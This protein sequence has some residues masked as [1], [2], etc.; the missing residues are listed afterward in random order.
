MLV[1][2]RDTQLKECVVLF[3]SKFY[4]WFQCFL[5]F[6]HIVMRNKTLTTFL[7]SRIWKECKQ[8]IEHSVFLTRNTYYFAKYTRFGCVWIWWLVMVK[9]AYRLVERAVPQ[10][11]RLQAEVERQ[12]GWQCQRQLVVACRQGLLDRDFNQPPSMRPTSDNLESSCW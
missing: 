11:Q 7:Y 9:N 12:L 6:W 4:F 3:I 2:M 1:V 8:T 10:P 5:L